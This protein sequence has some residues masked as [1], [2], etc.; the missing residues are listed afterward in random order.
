MAGTD[1]TEGQALWQPGRAE[2]DGRLLEG[3]MHLHLAYDEEEE[4][5]QVQNSIIL[6]KINQQALVPQSNQ[7]WVRT[8]VMP[9]GLSQVESYR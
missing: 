2:E 1:V 7:T 5:S 9:W 4:E 3:N 6:Q 8:P